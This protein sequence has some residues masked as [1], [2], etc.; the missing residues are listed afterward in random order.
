M[1]D[2]TAPAPRRFLELR[3]FRF[4]IWPILAGGLLMEGLLRLGRV[5][6]WWLWHQGGPGWADRPWIYVGAAI[7]FQALIGLIAI[8]AMKRLLPRA[9]AHL[10]WPAKGR[11]LAGLAV[12]LGIGMGLFMLVAD[13]WPNLFSHTVP[14]DYPVDPVNAAGWLAAMGITGLAEETLFRGFLLGALAVLVPGRLRIGALDLPVAAYFVA[15]IFG[16]MHWQSFLVNPLH[17]AIAQ[18]LYAFAW[19]LIYAWLME[20]SDSLLAPVIAHGVS[21]FAEVGMVMLITA[22]LA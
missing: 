3:D 8:A 5:P 20:R 11:S 14:S 17:L 7:L 16:A 13:Y 21:D 12:L 19:G 22:A 4:R 2:D 1:T 10:R 18:Q 15:L 6:A 9:D